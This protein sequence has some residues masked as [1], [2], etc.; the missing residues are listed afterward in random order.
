M[1]FT[2]Q[3]VLSPLD[4]YNILLQGLKITRGF[5][6]FYDCLIHLVTWYRHRFHEVRALRENGDD[7]IT[8]FSRYFHL[9]WHLFGNLFGSESHSIK[10]TQDFNKG[11][12]G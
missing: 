11:D 5:L 9:A 2:F 4:L 1:P 7:M 3:T 8:T 12:L 10:E 6:D